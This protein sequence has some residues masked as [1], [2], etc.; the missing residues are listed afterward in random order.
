MVCKH[1]KVLFQNTIV[2]GLE[3]SALGFIW[4]FNPDASSYGVWGWSQLVVLIRQLRA[5]S[6]VQFAGEGSQ[7]TK[8]SHRV[9]IFSLQA[10]AT[11]YERW[12]LEI[13]SRIH[14]RRTIFFSSKFKI[15]MCFDMLDLKWHLQEL[16]CE[17]NLNKKA[18]H[19][20]LMDFCDVRF[21]F[22]PRVNMRASTH[23]KVWFEFSFEPRVN[24]RDSMHDQLLDLCDNSL[25]HTLNSIFLR[26]SWAIIS[27]P[28][29]SLLLLQHES[30]LENPTTPR[31]RRNHADP[32][33]TSRICY[34]LL[35]AIL[36]PHIIKQ[37]ID[38]AIFW[39]RTMNFITTSQCCL[40]ENSL[41][42]LFVQ[43]FVE[44]EGECRD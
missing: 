21:S 28:R 31:M 1:V 4:R 13:H 39:L 43:E 34:R 18:Q 23:M 29:T 12:E 5:T 17:R 38:W 42:K 6:S 32:I 19:K 26:N 35:T 11:S 40:V 16:S 20:S 22:E 7:R 25:R 2:M 3:G 30:T 41:L 8:W 27:S 24:I 10:T 44:L 15:T 14:P 33:E 9:V 37:K 36:A